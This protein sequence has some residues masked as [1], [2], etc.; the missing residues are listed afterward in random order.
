MRYNR[1]FIPDLLCCM[2]AVSLAVLPLSGQ[3]LYAVNDAIV[4][5]MPSSLTVELL[6]LPNSCLMTA[7]VASW[8]WI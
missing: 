4:C 8:R 5:V 7:T 6:F 1:V 3:L 2:T